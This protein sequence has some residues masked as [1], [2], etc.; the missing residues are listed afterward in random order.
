VVGFTVKKDGTLANI[1]VVESVFPALDAEV[2]RVIG[3]S[4]LLWK[5]AIENGQAQESRI[6]WPVTFKLG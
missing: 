4:K 6:V 2:I 1:E 5:P 3:E